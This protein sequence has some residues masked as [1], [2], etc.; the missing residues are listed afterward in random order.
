MIISHSSNTNSTSDNI[1]LVIILL[2]PSAPCSGGPASCLA[3]PGAER[4]PCGP[5]A[6]SPVSIMIISII[7]TS[8]STI[9]I[10]IIIVTITITF[11]ITITITITIIIIVTIII[12][13]PCSSGRA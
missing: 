5:A 4:D 10:T 1:V 9:T 7:I 11:T 12:I 6:R 2:K 3:D 13:S 8:T